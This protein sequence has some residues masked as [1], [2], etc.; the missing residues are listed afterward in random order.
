M[1]FTCLFPGIP[2]SPV[3]VLGAVLLFKKAVLLFWIV[4]AGLPAASYM[5]FGAGVTVISSPS[6]VLDRSIPK[7]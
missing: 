1:I 3:G 4:S 5:A 6:G 7:V 2:T